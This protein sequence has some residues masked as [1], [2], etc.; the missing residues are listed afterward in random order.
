MR[1]WQQFRAGQGPRLL[2]IDSTEP[3]ALRQPW[4]LLADE[5]GH[6]FALDIPLRRRVHVA[7]AAP[8]PSFALPLRVLMVVARPQD[9]RTFFIDPRASSQAL[10]AALAPLG[11]ANAVVEFLHA[12]TLVA[13]NRRMRDRRQPPVHTVHFDGHGLD[14]VPQG[15]GYLAFEDTTLAALPSHPGPPPAP[16]PAA[17]R[18]GGPGGALPR[19]LLRPLAL[20]IPVGQPLPPRGPAHRRPRAAQPAPGPRSGPGRR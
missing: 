11:P 15:L 5:E 3:E 4:E 2:T 19:R 12:P 7:Q 18:A 1:L 14:V 6:L 20:S 9:P 10:L 17:R 8:V 16:P 13:L